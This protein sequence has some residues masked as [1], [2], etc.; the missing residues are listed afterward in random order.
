VPLTATPDHVAVAVHDI[1]AAGKRWVDDLGGVWLAPRWDEGGGFATRQL[2]FGNGAKLELLE[3][4]ASGGFAAGFLD[5]YGPRIHHVTL[6]V[7]DLHE[8]VATVEAAGYDVVDLSFARD[9]WHEGFLRPSHVGGIIVQLAA[10]TFTDEAW[11]QANGSSVAP[12]PSAPALVGP[13]LTH[14]D[15]DAAARLWA[16][17]GADVR[18]LGDGSLEARWAGAPLT[19]RIEPG[20]LPGPRG[21]RFSPDPMLA[22][23]D[24]A[25]PGTLPA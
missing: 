18:D 8:A 5:R 7:P 22:A 21:L 11:E 20:H 16:T 4:T 23:D 3:P 10:T 6:K 25:G 24:V 1:E 17:L 19:V 12:D 14:T 13:S 2:R 9:E 15:L